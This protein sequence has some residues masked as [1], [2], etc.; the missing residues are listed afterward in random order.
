MDTLKISII[1]PFYNTPIKYFKECLKALKKLNPY[2]VILIDDCSTNEETINEALNSRFKYFKTPYQ[3]GYDGLPLNIG[4]QNATGE[5]ICRIDSDDILLELPKVINT[6]I[7]FGRQDRVLPATNLTLEELILAP[8]A[9]C[10]ALV[11]KREIFLKHP[12]AIDSNVYG[13]VLFLLQL[14]YNKYSF[15]VFPR[16]NYIYTK[17]EDSIQSSKSALFHRL[18]HIQTVSRLC[19]LENIS[20]EESTHLLNLA[21]LNFKYGSKALNYLKNKKIHQIEVTTYCNLQCFY[22]P[23][24][25]IENKHIEYEKFKNIV[26]S[27]KPNST[28]RLQGTGE[29]FLHPKFYEMLTYVKQKGHYAD[30]I[31]N[32]TIKIKAKYI[33]LLDSIGFSIDTLEKQEAKNSKRYKLEITLENLFNVRKQNQRKVKIFATDYKQD[34]K[35]LKEFAK[36]HEIPL[37]IQSLQ[38]KT[39]Y[40]SKY[41]LKEKEYSNYSCK[42]IDHDL[43]QF[44]F[45]DGTVAPCCYMVD[46]SLVKTK[47]E[48]KKMLDE[49]IVPECC[50]QCGELIKEI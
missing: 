18:T 25:T 41:K 11:A 48:I 27:F 44:Y 19:Q 7:C 3:S 29:P 30:V 34:L 47:K 28:V 20:H 35:P 8:R 21:M 39:S 24:E 33:E 36:K 31:T 49:K 2:E 22:C 46:K 13:D 12:F 38:T 1:V 40:Q 42:Y 15:S 4:V 45:V 10:N 43:M 6:D 23:I 17:R 14:L 37:I 26:D 5:Y 50:K 16:V 9:L 32:G